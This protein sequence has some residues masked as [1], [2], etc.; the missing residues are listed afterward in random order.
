MDFLGRAAAWFADPAHWQGGDGIPIRI[1]EHVALSG[2]SLLV[3]VLIALPIGLYIGHTGRGALVAVS[4]SNIGRA[5]PSF[6]VLGMALPLTLW[7][8]QQL[9]FRAG[10]VGV[11]P[12]FIALALLAIPPIVTNS[13]TGLREV[14]R[15]LVEAARGMGMTGGQL[16]RVVELPL[17]MPIILAGLRTSAVQ[18]IATATL[19]AVFGAGGLGRYIIDGLATREYERV[20]AGAVIVGLLS[21][22]TELAFVWLQ[23]RTQPVTGPRRETGAAAA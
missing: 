13:Y 9:D 23:R 17:A 12:T 10:G 18:V 5:L 2:V 3:G 22:L 21:I 16:L 19:G 8:Q 15:D 20:F 1:L 6:G 14:D 4:V 7:L 11:L